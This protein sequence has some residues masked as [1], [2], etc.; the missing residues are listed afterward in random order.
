MRAILILAACTML[1]GC[2]KSGTLKGS[3]EVAPTPYGFTVGCE[4]N[5]DAVMCP[6]K[7]STAE[8]AK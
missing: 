3:G 2:A 5:P 1:A 6:K 7:K 4:S 8:A